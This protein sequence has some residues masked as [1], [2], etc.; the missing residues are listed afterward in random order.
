MREKEDS[1]VLVEIGEGLENKVQ[2]PPILGAEA[3]EAVLL[4]LLLS[5]VE[6]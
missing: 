2:G 3:M 5:E 4:L 1:E 6:A